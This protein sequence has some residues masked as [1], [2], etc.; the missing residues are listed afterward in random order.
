MNTPGSAAGSEHDGRAAPAGT[1]L[2]HTAARRGR[3]SYIAACVAILGAAAAIRICG[4]L[5][6]LWLDEIWS[7]DLA[8]QISS[9]ISVFTKLHHE[10]NHYLNTLYIYLAGDR[11]NWLGYRVPSLVGGIATVGVAGLIG[12][13]RDA[14][15]AIF[16]MVV[17][18]SSY[19][20][21]LYSSEVRGY[22]W[23]V[24]FALLSFYWL[25]AYMERPGWR[26]AL[27]FSLTSVLGLVTTPVFVGTLFA[28]LMW[29]G[30]RLIRSRCEAGHVAR[31]LASCYAAP[32]VF[33]AV[34]YFVDLRYLVAGG[35][36]SGSLLN[37]YVS[38]LAWAVGAPSGGALAILGCIAAVVILDAGIRMLRQERSDSFT[39]FLGAIVACPLLLAI[40]RGSNVVYVRHFIIA[41]TFL[42]ILFSFLLARLFQAGRSGRCICAGLLAI[43]VVAN[44]WHA[45]TLATYGRGRYSDAVRY[46]AEHSKR[47]VVEIG[48][49]HDFRIGTVVAFYVGAGTMGTREARYYYKDARPPDGPEWVICHKESY[50][51][52]TP[53]T[54]QITDGAGHVLE[55]VRTFQCAPLAG[56]HWF[57]FQRRE[58][59]R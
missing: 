1:P 47:P 43:Y 9:P 29:S 45:V 44:G 51:D 46:I 50:E 39:F 4:A 16:A 59:A 12:R 28:A 14:P 56:L 32:F 10:N 5:N 49:D 31:A 48:G 52:P 38:A 15:S 6:D 42:Q 7:L 55:F 17:T 3:W 30:Y 35:G 57:V 53:P 58:P 23:L 26:L 2:S 20:L 27:L 18:G 40:V 36:T 13:R 33:L 24:F 11:G 22:A 34:L 54:T 41:I 37:C 19:V 8:R 21:I 25:D